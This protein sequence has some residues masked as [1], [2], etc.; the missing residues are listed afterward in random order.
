MGVSVIMTALDEPY[1]NKTIDDIIDKSGPLLKEI[2]VVDDV[3]EEP[4]QHDEARVIRNKERKGLIW[5]RNHSTGLAKSEVVLSLDPHCKVE[6]GWLEP[7]CDVLEQNESS[8]VVPGTRSLNPEK[9]KSFG[10]EAFKTVW[11]WDLEFR[12]AKGENPF[13]PAVAGHC[14]AFKKDWWE[15]AGRFDEGMKIWGGENI[16]FPL[17]TWLFGGSVIC[18]KDSH[19]SHW[20]KK[21]FQYSFPGIVLAQNKARVAEVWFDEYKEV[22]YQR[23][24]RPRGS[25]NFGDLRERLR[26]KHR[27]QKKSFKWFMKDISPKLWSSLYSRPMNALF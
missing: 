24:K 8:I 13:T 2:I 20:F 14:F 21:Q 12:W 5:G 11:D 4:I 16:E 3:S 6:K 17:R 22:F 7:L 18:V 19:V 27:M 26:I 10:T 1:V 25:I 15:T 23:M 9:W